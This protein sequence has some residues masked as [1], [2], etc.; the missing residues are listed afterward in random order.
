MNLIMKNDESNYEESCDD[1]EIDPILL[2]RF[3]LFLFFNFGWLF[4]K[5]PGTIVCFLFLPPLFVPFPPPKVQLTD[6]RLY[7]PI[8]EPIR[9]LGVAIGEVSDHLGPKGVCSKASSMMKSKEPRLAF[10]GL[11]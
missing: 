9:G 6:S 8:V 11:S 5:V 1:V 10:L 2:T 3:G 7:T 4:P